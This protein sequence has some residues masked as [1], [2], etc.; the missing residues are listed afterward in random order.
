M[1]NIPEHLQHEAEFC[2]RHF[3]TDPSWHA[4]L[5]TICDY[6]QEAAGQHALKLG[7]GIDDLLGNRLTWVLV[8]MS[9]TMDAYPSAGDTVTVRTQSMGFHRLYAYRRY[10]LLDAAGAE[11]GRAMSQWV[12][13]DV[14]SGKVVRPSEEMT[15]HVSVIVKDPPQMAKIAELGAV[16][17]EKRLIVRALDLDLN[18]HVNNAAYVGL[19]QE[20]LLDQADPE[21]FTL[22][23]RRFEIAYKD[24]AVYGDELLSQAQTLPDGGT[25]HRILRATDGKELVRAQCGW[26]SGC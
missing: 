4:R 26:V 14:E 22:Q 12:V 15:S 1:G 5:H 3:G 10:E 25:L 20:S 19:V 8:R 21:S 16:E 13:L 24:Q 17:R 23:P 7:I 11:L 18:R 6:F 2:V 9:V